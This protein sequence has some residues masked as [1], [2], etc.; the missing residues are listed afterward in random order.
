MSE[1]ELLKNRMQKIREQIEANERENAALQK[2]LSGLNRSLQKLLP[3]KPDV[4][5]FTPPA[6][7]EERNKF[8]KFRSYFLNYKTG[9]LSV[10]SFFDSISARWS[11]IKRNGSPGDEQLFL[12]EL[13]STLGELQQ[14][15][16]HS[17]RNML[18]NSES[19]DE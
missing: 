8:K 14:R 9:S 19:A 16:S 17:F 10:R 11:H 4:V 1:I 7:V 2:N 5:D 15:L 18:N 3:P 13:N 12:E 6:L